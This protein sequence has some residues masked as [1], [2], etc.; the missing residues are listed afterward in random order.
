MLKGTSLYYEVRQLI[1][2][3]FFVNISVFLI[4]LFFGF[5]MSILLGL[6]IGY[7][8]ICFSMILLAYSINE[9][10]SK[11]QD[12]AKKYMLFCYILRYIVLAA[13]LAIAA[14]VKYI[15][16]IGV[17]IPVLYPKFV[18]FAKSFLKGG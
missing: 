8:Y 12:K 18:L 1:I 5:K 6:L 2:V 13:L 9:S 3:M 7:F 16:I 17:I 11:T 15:S 14:N 10:V 4:S